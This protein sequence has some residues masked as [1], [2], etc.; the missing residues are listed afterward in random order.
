M[1]RIFSYVIYIFCLIFVLC[2]G[3]SAVDV[4]AKSAYALEA[5][6]GNTVFEKN[7]DTKMSMASTTKIMTAIVAIE[8]SSLD[9][10]VKITPEMVGIEGSSIY[11]QEGENLTVEELLYAL[12]LESANDASI[13]LAYSVGGSVEGFVE[14]MNKKADDLGLKSTH[15]TNPH[16][17]DNE[18][19]YTTAREL[20][21]IA[22]YAMENP[23]F[24]EIVSTYKRV[25]PLG[26]D[27]SRVLINHNKLLRSYEG[28]IGVKTGFTKKS[29]RC[30]VSC[31]EVDGVRII[32]VT[33]NATSDW[34]DHTKMLD[35][36]FSMYE[37]IKLA[38]TGDYNISLDVINGN[39]SS[40]LCSNLD[41]LDVTLEC[42]NNNIS[43]HLEAN[44]MISAP[45]KQGD[46][47]GKIIFKNNGCKI[48]SLD[49]YALESVKG[50]RYKKS[51]FE[52]IF[53]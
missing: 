50:I 38:D 21:I 25:I 20:A 28:A 12:L 46:C 23:V 10:V 17:L 45:I 37:N 6:S 47:V 36:G 51:I 3:C 32:A 26:E 41:S 52:R 5:D 53:G 27:G 34:N 43:A 22:R 35:L 4:S 1:C 33:L 15:F 2:I 16:G 7:A 40:V 42:D 9:K 24:N 13:A 19:H 48:A 8:N 44:R 11:L 31:A 18:E 14:L 30:L 29:G 39:K 49:L